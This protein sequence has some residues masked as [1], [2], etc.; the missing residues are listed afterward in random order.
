MKTR[1]SGQKKQ[2]PPARRGE[3]W[4]DK[5]AADHAVVFFSRYLRHV[6]GKWAGVPFVLEPWQEHGI[7]RPLFGWKRADGTRQYRRA[8]IA[9][10]RK[11]GKST[12]AA[13]IALY[14]LFADRESGAEVY[15]AAAD[16]DQAAIVFELAKSMVEASPQLKKRSQRFKRSIVG[17]RASSYKVLSADAPTKH[18]LNAH[19]IIF[20]E[21]HAQPNRDLWDVLTTSTGAREQPMVV[22]ITT[23]GYN[24]SSICYEEYAYAKQV[25]AGAIKDPSFFPFIAEADVKDGWA[26]PAVWEKANPGMGVTVRRE[27][28]EE[29]AKRAKESPAYQ[30][31]FRRLHLNQWV[32]QSTRWLDLAVWDRGNRLILEESLRGKECYA[33]LDLSSVSD[34]TAWVMAFPAEGDPEALAVVARFWCPQARLES[35]KYR[36]QYQAWARGGFLTPTPG[37]AIDYAFVRA[38]IIDDAQRFRL[39]DANVDRLFQAHQLAQELTEEG[40]AIF[41]MGQGFTGM[42]APMSEF[43]RRVLAGKLWHGGNPVLRWMVDNLA[44]KQDPAGNLKPDKA[45][46]QGKIDGVVAL[47]MAIDRAMR[48]EGSSVYESR[49]I[50]AL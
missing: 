33:G 21:L 24:Q 44:V 41:G 36:D 42:A 43:H 17:P 1:S 23:A 5:A 16:R 38:Q 31:T 26:D 40:L 19:G 2:K 25:H 15:S 11:N 8:F 14:L 29:E 47:V 50:V 39:V 7:I 9:V 48:H 6:K 46:S 45:S 30:N 20:D 32:Q 13:G 3:F 35:G 34:L 49:G 12:L 4:F 22:A 37:D 27:Y 28:L 18:G 10:P